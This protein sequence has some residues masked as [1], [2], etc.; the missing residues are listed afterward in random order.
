MSNWTKCSD[1]IPPI[2]VPVLVAWDGT[3][4][5]SRAV[6][7]SAMVRYVADDDLQSNYVRAWD[8]F[9][10]ETDR[11]CYWSDDNLPTHWALWPEFK[12]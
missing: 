11:A 10:Y 3:T 12:P 6:H 7:Y 1:A 9:E 5:K 4:R 2:G 8:W